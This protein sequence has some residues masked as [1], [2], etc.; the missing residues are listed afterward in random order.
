MA[1]FFYTFTAMDRL[2]QMITLKKTK[3]SAVD[4]PEPTIH[5]SY[6]I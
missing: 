6:S 3:N 1:Y 4:V 5:A 2:R